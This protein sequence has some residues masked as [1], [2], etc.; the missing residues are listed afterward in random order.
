MEISESDL[1]RN[2][3]SID[4]AIGILID[5][6]KV[7]RRLGR[8]KG[9]LAP[10]VRLLINAKIQPPDLTPWMTES[11]SRIKVGDV[12]EVQDREGLVVSTHLDPVTPR[13]T[14][15]WIHLN[16]W[17]YKQDYSPGE[18]VRVIS[19]VNREEDEEGDS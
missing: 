18:Q 1:L 4:A 8:D 16:A 17:E 7:N 9:D 10:L 2:N 12:I 3:T 19:K 6:Q 11:A 15:G 14:L 5:M 13:I